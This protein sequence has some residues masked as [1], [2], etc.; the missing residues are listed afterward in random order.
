MARSQSA[1]FPQ[2]A[3]RKSTNGCISGPFL[4]RFASAVM[5]WPCI[6][7]N[8]IIIRKRR[9]SQPRRNLHGKDRK[10]T[11]NLQVGGSERAESRWG[12]RGA[13]L[14]EEAQPSRDAGRSQVCAPPQTPAHE[15]CLSRPSAAPQHSVQCVSD[16]RP[17]ADRNVQPIV[18]RK[19]RF[20][21]TRQ[22]AFEQRLFCV[23][24]APIVSL[25]GPAP[26]TAPGLM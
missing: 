13:R 10:D 3:K 17:A 9:R 8:P 24:P 5:N 25:R 19:L 1:S 16:A 15:Q 2:R 18:F 22:C 14:E 20:S 7:N 26:Q 23:F 6:S 12:W 4:G 21:H 11:V